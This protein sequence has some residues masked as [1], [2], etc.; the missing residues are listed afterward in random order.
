MLDKEAMDI[1]LSEAEKVKRMLSSQQYVRI[2]VRKLF[3][4]LDFDCTVSL[5]EFEAISSVLMAKTLT[6][7]RDLLKNCKVKAEQVKN[8][9]LVGG[10]TRMPAVRK[11]LQT[12]FHENT[13]IAINADEDVARGAALLA[14][15]NKFKGGTPNIMLRDVTPNPLGI[16]AFDEEFVIISRSS[17]TSTQCSRIGRC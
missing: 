16:A 9:I 12:L 10:S 11:N 1:L 3:N 5:E 17:L 6:I 4:G 13:I 7:T 8:V 15:T 14:G 2:K